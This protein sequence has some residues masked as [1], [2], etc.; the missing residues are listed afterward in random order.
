MDSF[1]YST[2]LSYLGIQS[3]LYNMSHSH[4]HLN[5]HFFPRL[6]AF[7]LMFILQLSPVAL[8]TFH[9]RVSL[10]IKVIDVKNYEMLKFP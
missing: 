9:M 2:F 5:K 4:T 3:V 1:S 7:S 10:L 6:N 8:L